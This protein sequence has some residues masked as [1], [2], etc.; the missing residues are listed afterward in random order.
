MKLNTLIIGSGG[1]EHAICRSIVKSPLSKNVFVLPGNPGTDKIANNINISIDRFE[2]ILKTIQEKEIDILVC[3]PE[4]PLADGLMDF[5]SERCPQDSIILIGP[6]QIAAQLESSKA[7][8]KLF[9]QRH[10]IPTAAYGIFKSENIYEAFDFIDQLNI[11]IVL[12]ADGLAAGKG[13]LICKDKAEARV[14]LREMISGKFGEA[15]RTVVIEEF[16]DGIE[17]S[18]FVLTDGSDFVL[19]PEA[20]DYKRIGEGDTGLNTGGMGSVS[21]V[22]FFDETLKEKVLETIVKPTILGL[23]KENIPYCGFIFFGLIV[24]KGEPFVIEYNVRMGDPETESV[25]PRIKSDVV[26]L[27]HRC[28]TNRLADYDMQIDP[29]YCT[30]II[31]A[32]GGYPEA[33]EKGKSIVIPEDF[34]ADLMIFH[35]GTRLSGESLQTNGGRVLAL[36]SMGENKNAAIEKCKEMA[37]KIQYEGKYYRKDIGFG[38]E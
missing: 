17:F 16:L 34:N 7:F 14:E 31:L 27:F 3:G 10:Q 23:Q 36:S 9:M 37:E 22:S 38:L 19:L 20:K 12:K 2:D 4:A 1:R 15:S 21:P 25:F 32:S 8:A 13:V 18:L 33:F 6:N 11:P 26:D 5:L 30:T 35:S 29:N 24:V 28:G